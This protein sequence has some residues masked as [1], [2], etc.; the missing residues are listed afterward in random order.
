ME[1]AIVVHVLFLWVVFNNVIFDKI[2]PRST[3]Y[4]I[5]SAASHIVHL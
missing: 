4:E 5:S 3:L 2:F 1:K